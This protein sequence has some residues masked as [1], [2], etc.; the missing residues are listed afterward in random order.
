MASHAVV[1]AV[2]VPGDQINLH[3]Y[4]VDVILQI[5]GRKPPAIQT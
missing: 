1:A 3:I 2:M 4:D 5:C